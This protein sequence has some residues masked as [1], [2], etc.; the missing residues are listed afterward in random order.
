M[1]HSCSAEKALVSAIEVKDAFNL[2]F[3]LAF[4]I[5]QLSV[6]M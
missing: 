1:T 5:L 4:D 3:T 2:T 6:I